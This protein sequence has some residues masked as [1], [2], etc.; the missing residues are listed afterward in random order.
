MAEVI[1][2]DYEALAKVASQFQNEAEAIQQVLQMVRGSMT[3]L[4]NG[5]WIG[6]G[7]DAFF[8]EMESDVL[9]AVGRLTDALTQAG[10]VSRQI[11]D[12]MQSAEEEA[13]SPFRTSETGG[14]GMF[15]PQDWLKNLG[16]STPA[17]GG[18]NANDFGIPFNWLEGVAGDMGVG[19]GSDN[20]GIPEDWLEGVTNGG[21]ATTGGA[22]GG[23]AA[24]AESPGGG[25]TGG[26]GGTS[27]SPTEPQPAPTGGSGGSQTEPSTDINSPYGQQSVRTGPQTLFDGGQVTTEAQKGRLSY[28]SLNVAANAPAA[29]TPAPITTGG[30][31]NTAPAPTGSTENGAGIGL[32]VA[33]LTPLMGIMGKTVKDLLSDD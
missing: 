15:V 19:S 1:R 16:G 8:N 32:A 14:G 33:A 26:S 13:G 27:G 4:Q 7:S 30:T 5:G 29:G 28:Q 12:L 22:T 6:Q 20:W 10:G 18:N 9:P 21:N 17:T 23:S 25:A 3:P 24:S 31:G 11:A 2:V